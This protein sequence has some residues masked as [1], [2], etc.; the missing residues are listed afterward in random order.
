MYGLKSYSRPQLKLFKAEALP[1]RE[2][3]ALSVVGSHP[4]ISTLINTYKNPKKLYVF[5]VSDFV[6]FY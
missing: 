6:H 3:A 5:R 1:M 4:F 2:K